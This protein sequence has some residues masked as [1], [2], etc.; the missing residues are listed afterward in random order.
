MKQI[1]GFRRASATGGPRTLTGSG[2]SWKGV[3]HSWL[4]TVRLGEAWLPDSLN[5]PTGG[6]DM[7]RGGGF[8]GPLSPS[9]EFC[10]IRGPVWR[11]STGKPAN[12]T[13]VFRTVRLERALL[14]RGRPLLHETL[15]PGSRNALRTTQ[16]AETQK[17]AIWRPRIGDPPHDE[18][19]RATRQHSTTRGEAPFQRGGLA[20]LFRASQTGRKAIYHA[21][22]PLIGAGRGR[23]RPLLHEAL[24]LG[25]RNAL[26]PQNTQKPKKSR[27]GGLVLGTPSR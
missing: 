26:R 21:V 23:G 27:F 3:G 7:R 13:S 1:W 17:I 20:Q 9:V 4:Q 18:P 16:H 15:P 11:L 5:A 8:S 10:R 25:S 22:W 12:D 6:G 24:L 2:H 19:F 14:S